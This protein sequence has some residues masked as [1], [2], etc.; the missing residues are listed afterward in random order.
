LTTKIRE[1]ADQLVTALKSKHGEM[2]ALHQFAV[3]IFS[4]N[5]YE[6][7]AT[8][9]DKFQSITECFIALKVLKPDGLFAQPGDTTGLFAHLKY[10]IRGACIYEAKKWQHLYNNSLTESVCFQYIPPM[11]LNIPSI[12]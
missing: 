2:E 7:G 3:P 10:L 1:R 5:E 4:P 6:D 11:L 12:V 8:K 9:T